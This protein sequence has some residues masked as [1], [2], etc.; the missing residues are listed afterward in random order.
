[1]NKERKKEKPKDDVGHER[2]CPVLLSLIS[3]EVTGI[4]DI[5]PEEPDS[6]SAESMGHGLGC[7]VQYSS[8][9]PV[10]DKE[11]LVISQ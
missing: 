6:S 3:P 9:G 2:N 5:M 11:Q 10:Q 7:I 8:A 1:M 4:H